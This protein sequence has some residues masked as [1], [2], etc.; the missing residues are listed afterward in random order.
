MGKFKLRQ[1][2]IYATLLY[3]TLGH[4]CLIFFFQCLLIYYNFTKF[5]GI[6]QALGHTRFHGY[7]YAIL[8]DDTKTASETVSTLSFFIVN[9]MEEMDCK[10]SRS[11][12]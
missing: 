4:I 2:R 3:I 6:C 12:G 11:K 1:E 9:Y 5:L 10:I 8:L 7:R